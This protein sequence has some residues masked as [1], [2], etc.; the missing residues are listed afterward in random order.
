MFLPIPSMGDQHYHAYAP[1]A[2]LDSLNR[3]WQ[4]H[5]GFAFA[6][7]MPWFILLILI[8][9]I[10]IF[11]HKAQTLQFLDKFKWVLVGFLVLCSC[12]Y[13]VIIF[14][15]GVLEP[16][17]DLTKHFHRYPP[18]GK[19]LYCAWYSLVGVSEFSVRL[20]SLIFCY[21]AA[22]YLYRLVKLFKDKETA[23]IASVIFV[24]LPIV[25]HYS[26][27]VYLESG[28]TFF[29]I[30]ASFYFMRYML[31]YRFNDLVLTSFL[32]GTG[33]L[34]K[35]SVLPVWL[36]IV[37]TASISKK[38]SFK[39]ILC[40]SWFSLVPI[41]PWLIIQRLFPQRVYTFVPAN[42]LSLDIIATQFKI[43]FSALTPVVCIVG[44][45]GLTFLLIRKRDL[46]AVYIG[47][48][49]SVY[50]LLVTGEQFYYLA[51]FMLLAYPVWAIGGAVFLGRLG[52]IH[53]R[54]TGIAF[55]L[56]II[57]LMVINCIARMSPLEF[58]FLNIQAY[59]PTVETIYLPYGKLT[60][61]IKKHIPVGSKI[62]APMKCEPS[63]FYLT[64]NQMTDKYVWERKQWLTFED[65]T[66][67]N[68]YQLCQQ[69]GF[70]YLVI[71]ETTKKWLNTII[72]PE[73]VKMVN[74]DP[75]FVPIKRCALG[76]NALV[77]YQIIER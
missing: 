43:A 55:A 2:I 38:V 74:E 60:S 63:H 6:P 50:Y 35:D 4:N 41:I 54:L 52:K 67:K 19:I 21:T 58:K 39:T 65:Q 66:I 75:R 56:L 76:K 36:A 37:M 47:V 29:V 42:F 9:I 28:V 31:Q 25:F 5:F 20:V 45:L 13:V 40:M 10:L 70:K 8:G 34:Y 23:L 69:N 57:Y 18:L 72:R 32:I 33:F 7:I 17:G 53:A 51:R 22:F 15:S 48:W 27:T 68:L 59:D 26:H 30:A 49:F 61:Y 24:F 12:L 11:H 44:L 3:L 1:L 46:F 64:L 73:L 16:L 71:P 62:L 77:L 14:R